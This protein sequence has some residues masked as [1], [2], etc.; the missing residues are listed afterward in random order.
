[1]VIHLLCHD[2]PAARSVLYLPSITLVNSLG[3]P[4]YKEHGGLPL[5]YNLFI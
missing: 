1:M 4:F 2:N 3:G 5:K